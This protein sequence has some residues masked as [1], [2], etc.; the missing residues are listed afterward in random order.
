MSYVTRDCIKNQLVN[1][2]PSEIDNEH[3]KTI[4]K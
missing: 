4:L 3:L 1:L 2:I